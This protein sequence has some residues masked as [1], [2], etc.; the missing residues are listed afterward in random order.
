MSMPTPSRPWDVISMDF[1][2]DLPE[3][4]GFTMIFVAVDYFSKQAHFIPAKPP[5]TTYQTARLFFKNVF[6]SH[7]LPLAIVSDRDGR[8]LS[9][10]WQELFKLLGTQ[11]RFSSAYHPQTDGQTERINQGIEDYI[12]SYVQA[13]Q[14]DWADFLEVLE[15]QY[16][17]SVHTGTGYAPFEL[18]T[19]K[20]V[21]TPM[22]LASGAIHAQDLDAEEFL[23]KWQ[24]RM[25]VARK[26]L[27]TYK[28]KY[29]AKANE[30]ARAE[31][32]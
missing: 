8:F 16:N 19:G 32:F 23:A 7:G 11:L 14:K 2:V 10:M 3:S 27:V 9:D 20:E 4:H 22:A 15:F 1:I 28:E 13:D 25:E 31:F 12:R 5:L 24:K 18:A 21:I 26:H 6:K 30:K 17:S 29:V